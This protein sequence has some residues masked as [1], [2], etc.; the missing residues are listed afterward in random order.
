[1]STDSGTGQAK[2]PRTRGYEPS[3][4]VEKGYTPA[5]KPHPQGGKV[6]PPPPPKPTTSAKPSNK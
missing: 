6:P 1:M 3:K 5:A 4:P 2:P